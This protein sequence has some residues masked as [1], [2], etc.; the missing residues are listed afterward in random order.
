MPRLLLIS[1]VRWGYLWQRHQ[2]LAV[3]AAEA[4]WTV[5]F[6]QP[7]PRNMRQ[8]ATYPVRMATGSRV[9]QSHGTTPAGVNVLGLRSWFGRLPSYDLAILYIPDRI[10][11]WRISR[12][13]MGH[14]IYDAVLDWATVPRDWYPPLGW[15]KSEQRIARRP[16]TLVTTDSEGMAAILA[17]RGIKGHVLPPAADPPFISAGI[18]ATTKKPA[19]LYFGSIRDEVDVPALIHLARSGL[20]VEVI[21]RIEQPELGRRL[22]EGGVLVRGPLPVRDLAEVAAQFQVLVLPYRGDRATSLAPAKYWNCVAAQSWVITHGLKVPT[23]APNV[24]ATDG[25]LGDLL[26]CVRAALETR[27]PKAPAPTWGTRWDELLD[28]LPLDAA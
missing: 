18:A 8:I 23:A 11:E 26:T 25:T 4:G 1:S 15:K 10:T 7:R 28:L 6:L 5:D 20:S 16:N 24:V 9:E 17:S 19:I 27:P 3:A 13:Q 21:G 12:V 14:T 22:V 2:A